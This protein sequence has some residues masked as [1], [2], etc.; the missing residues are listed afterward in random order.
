MAGV[1]RKIKDEAR[2]QKGQVSD[3]TEAGGVEGE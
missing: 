3:G 2:R 1:G